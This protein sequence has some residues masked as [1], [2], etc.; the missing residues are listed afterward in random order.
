MG[1]VG[2]GEAMKFILHFNTQLTKHEAE[3]FQESMINSWEKGVLIIPPRVTSLTIIDETQDNKM[4]YQY[5]PTKDESKDKLVIGGDESTNNPPKTVITKRT[6]RTFVEPRR[7]QAIQF[8]FEPFNKPT[9]IYLYWCERDRRWDTGMQY[10]VTLESV[11]QGMNMIDDLLKQGWK[12]Q[13][14]KT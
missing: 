2:R 11:E 8:T 3:G 10:M 7:Q 5:M 14:E 4:I 6:V 12:E 9:L 13:H 1:V